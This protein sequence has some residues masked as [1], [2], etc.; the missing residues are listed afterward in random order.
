MSR[1]RSLTRS[2][3]ANPTQ[4]NIVWFSITLLIGLVYVG[5][6]LFLVY[7]ANHTLQQL[8]ALRSDELR[9]E[10][11]QI[12]PLIHSL[13]EDLTALTI[14]TWPLTQSLRLFEFVPRIGPNLAALGQ[15]LDIASN[16]ANAADIVW[17]TVAPVLDSESAQPPVERLLKSVQTQS[18]NLIAAQSALQ[19]AIQTRADLP[20]DLSPV[21]QTQIAK[22][23]TYLPLLDQTVT[24]LRTLPKALGAEQPQTYLILI[25]N[26]DELRASG[27][28]I[29]S[30]GILRV[31]NGKVDLQVKNSYA[32]DDYANKPY[33]PPPA[34]LQV[35]MGADLWLF[36]DANW[37]AS[38]PGSANSIAAL[39]TLGQDESVAGV[40]ALDQTAVRYWLAATGPIVLTDGSTIS[41]ATV[42]ERL[43]SEWQ[44]EPSDL[45]PE[46]SRDQSSLLNGLGDALITR[47]FVDPQS[48]NLGALLNATQRA[49]E[50]KHLLLAIG[51]S[52]LNEIAGEHHW[53]GAIT[54]G[55]QDYLYI[56]DS[57]VGFN[58]ANAL[59]ERSINYAVD[60]SVPN[61]P[62]AQLLIRYTIS[63]SAT[64][65]CLQ[66][67]PGYGSQDYAYETQKCYWNYL[68]VFV[69][70]A[71][72]L[73]ESATLPTPA[74]WLWNNRF[75][76]GW[77]HQVE[78]ESG[79]AEF[80]Q[81]FVVP[82]GQSMST[83]FDYEL[84]ATV[85]HYEIADMTYCLDLIKQPGT[86][87]TLT[88]VKITLPS[89]S[90]FLESDPAPDSI[91][92]ST[93]TYDSFLLRTDQKL[94]A[95][96]TRP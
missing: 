4:F 95:T 71:A 52:S 86:D 25:Q 48:L 62:T 93:L 27:G 96:F 50:E 21:L 81:F 56:V 38:F 35:Y 32:I 94:C 9:S 88:Q 90:V 10:V 59:L 84:P 67:D 54:P 61:Q 16:S 2:L 40:I 80:N 53:I 33:P 17:Q 19:K 87:T 5:R 11:A 57:N 83:H 68:R 85:I 44:P 30:V 31:D 75:D 8:S 18:S 15:L 12:G 92:D 79:T 60:L 3:A 23:D 39:F 7:S 49:L 47:M 20:L 77:A 43:H 22:L 42:I 78:G 41:G 36:R 66:I 14:E 26:S 51:D 70:Q 29:S 74:D 28:F 24:V 73:I 46:A 58:K 89:D 13:N 55:D 72:R 82:L 63:G 76:P 37:A 1:L 45:S 64:L 91:S 34:A 69:P 65:H 6:V